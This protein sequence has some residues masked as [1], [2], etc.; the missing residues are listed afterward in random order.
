MSDIHINNLS[1][2][3]EQTTVIE[4]LSLHIDQGCFFTLLGP[5]GCGKTTLLRTLAGFITPAGGEIRFGQQ[6]V[7]RL[8]A[9]KRD[10]GLVFQDYALFPHH[11]VADN[12]GY[13]L[14][15]RGI[16]RGELQAR[17]DEALEQVALSNY[18]DRFPAQLSG[19]QKQRVALAR[20]LVIKPRLLLM[21]EPLSNLDAR[22]RLQM[23][24]LICRLQSESGIT[25]VFVTHDQEEALAMSDQIAIMQSGKIE[26]VGTPKEVYATPTNAYVADFIGSANLLPSHVQQTDAHASR[27]QWVVRPEQLILHRSAHPDCQQVLV[28]SAQYLGYKTSYRVEW[29]YEGEVYQL[30]VD[31]PYPHHQ[32]ELNE[33][34]RAYLAFPKRMHRV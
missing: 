24:E 12:I 32:I 15:A 4:Q 27:K 7:T 19:G 28:R 33:G 16:A 34:D 21:D 20:A 6:N 14:K 30:R 17:V 22:L 31:S 26:Q 13:G 18:R 25:T 5:S 8:P 29:A 11:N 1:I 10:I 23:R 9:H 2:Q 3:Y